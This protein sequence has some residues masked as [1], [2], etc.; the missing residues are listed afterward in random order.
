MRIRKNKSNN[1]EDYQKIK[2]I[3]TEAL[4]AI[5]L[6]EPARGGTII[7]SMPVRL[8]DMSLDIHENKN[9]EF[10]DQDLRGLIIKV[11][12]KLED[13]S[14][15]HPEP[16]PDNIDLIDIYELDDDEVFNENP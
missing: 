16:D 12:D 6:G 13:Y 4:E 5:E 7:L 8:Y 1:Q 10:F 2:E 3:Y 14:L 9:E 11:T 15:S